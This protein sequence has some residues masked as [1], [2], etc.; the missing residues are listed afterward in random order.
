VKIGRRNLRQVKQ[1][2]VKGN[3]YRAIPRI[4]QVHH[5]PLRVIFEE[6]FSLGTYPWTLR[7]RTPTGDVQA[8]VYSGADLS[9]A[10]LVFCR[11]DYHMPAGARVVVDVGSNIGLSSLYW[12]TRTTDVHVHCYE[13]APTSYQRLLENLEP[14][15]DRFTPHNVAVSDFRGTARLWMDPTGVKSSLD[16]R[17]RVVEPVAVEVLHVN[18]ILESVV[19]RHGQVDMLKLDN[20]GHEFRT[21]TAIAP[22]FWERITCVNVGCHDNRAAVPPEFHMTRVGSAERFLRH[23]G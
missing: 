13:P 3:P 15:G 19:S 18:D 7:L 14:Y 16:H 6:L 20:E 23:P 1:L 8:R 2:L 12:L 4:F 5:Q 17:E 22:E 21:L 11:Q 9:T 10:N